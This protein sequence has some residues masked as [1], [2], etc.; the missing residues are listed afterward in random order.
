MTHPLGDG[1]V[2]QGTRKVQPGLTGARVTLGPGVRHTQFAGKRGRVM[3]AIWS[4]GLYLVR[5]DDGRKYEAAP[6]NISLIVDSPAGPG[7]RL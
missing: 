7:R 5:L 4:R 3:K 6:A 2:P 1:S